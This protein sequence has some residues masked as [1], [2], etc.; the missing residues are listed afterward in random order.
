M[1]PAFIRL[2][3]S[4]TAPILDANASEHETD[5]IVHQFLSI[6][7]IYL[8]VE[9]SLKFRKTYKKIEENLRTPVVNGTISVP[10]RAVSPSDL[11]EEEAEDRRAFG[12]ARRFI[13]GGYMSRAAARLAQLVGVSDTVTREE[14]ITELKRLH[15]AERVGPCGKIDANLVGGPTNMTIDDK[16]M[17]T[18]V[19]KAC[20]G[21]ALGRTGWS[22]ELLRTLLNDNPATLS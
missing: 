10:T 12:A 4:H 5:E 21:A 11:S 6:P 15:P 13:A 3:H 22:P 2:V 16:T 1:R 18:I 14:K 8:R 19:N 9:G 7:K 17:L 20:N